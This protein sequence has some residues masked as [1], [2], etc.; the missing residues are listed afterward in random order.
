[1]CEFVCVYACASACV[2]SADVVVGQVTGMGGV[3]EITCAF[4]VHAS[5]CV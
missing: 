4:C 5:V 1:M 2:C 3:R